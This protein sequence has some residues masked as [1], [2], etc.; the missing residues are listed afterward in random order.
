MSKK[1]L[2]ADDS[3]VIQKSIGITFAQEDFDVAF[4]SN[5]EEALQRAK[6]FRPDLILADT[7]MPKLSGADLCKRFRQEPELRR[8]PILLL[9]NSQET[10]T[11]VQLK[12]FGA[13]DFIQKPFESTQLLD[14]VRPLLA[15]AQAMTSPEVTM[16]SPKTSV[17]E[18]QSNPFPE[19]ETV[20][21]Y[22]APKVP[23]RETPSI[24]L[25]PS[26][27]DIQRESSFKMSPE[28]QSH[29][30]VL[31]IDDGD[32]DEPADF[33]AVEMEEEP[34]PATRVL[35]QA[36][37]TDAP[38]ISQPAAPAPSASIAAPAT[39]MQTSSLQLSEAQIEQIVS[40]VFQNVIERI[41]WEVVPEMAER[42]IKD[43]IQ[44]ITADQ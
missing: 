14:K 17:T 20:A 24:D 21:R 6:E 37:K 39:S 36:A 31:S 28:T 3:V 44:K 40:K 33:A 29:L 25:D 30:D 5:G 41:A 4:V 22:E 35:H 42:I 10:F 43:E 9:S 23:P 1:I 15:Q 16:A 34:P 19:E 2:V 13:S 26:S 7:T 27:F 11:P 38:K 12:T 18:V 32:E 8:T